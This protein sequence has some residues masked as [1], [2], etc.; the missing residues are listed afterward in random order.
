MAR[1][2]PTTSTLLNGAR[3]RDHPAV[4][5][6]LEQLIPGCPAHIAGTASVAPRMPRSATV[7]AVPAAIALQ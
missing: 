7:L 1:G 4:S 6:V 2:S 3:P 5:R